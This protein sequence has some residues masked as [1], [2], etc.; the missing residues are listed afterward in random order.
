MAQLVARLVW[1]QQV[2]GSS[3][4]GPT[5]NTW[6]YPG[7]FVCKN[8]EARPRRREAGLLEKSEVPE[9]LAEKSDDDGA[10]QG[11][12][13]G[14]V[15]EEQAVRHEGEDPEDDHVRE[16]SLVRLLGQLPGSLLLV[17]GRKNSLG[18]ASLLV[19][20]RDEVT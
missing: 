2:A 16:Q 9:D 1:D 20:E 4:V 17:L 18:Q 7:V 19:G 13:N 12:E 6:I 5:K 8:G 11:D 15:D 3:P 10:V 14:L